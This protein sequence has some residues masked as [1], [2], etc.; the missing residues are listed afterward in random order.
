[1][2]NSDKALM[3][4]IFERGGSVSGINK[5]LFSLKKCGSVKLLTLISAILC[6]IFISFLFI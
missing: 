1:M 3:V 4:S 6:S 2:D 5:F